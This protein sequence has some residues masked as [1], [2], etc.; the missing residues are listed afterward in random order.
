[1]VVSHAVSGSDGTTGSADSSIQLSDVTVL[2][3]NTRYEATIDNKG[4]HV[5]A[6]ALPPGVNQQL[7][8]FFDQA[9]EYAGIHIALL[10]PDNVIDGTSGDASVGGIEISFSGTIPPVS[11][12][13]LPDPACGSAIRSVCLNQLLYTAEGEVAKN[14]PTTCGTDVEAR[15]E[16]FIDP[17]GKNPPPQVPLCFGAGVAPGPGS[18]I[19]LTINIGTAESFSDGSVLDFGF[20]PQPDPCPNGCSY[21]PAPSTMN[22]PPTQASVLGSTTYSPTQTQQRAT[23]PLLG[24]YARLPSALLMGLGIGLLILAV[25]AAL[26]PSLRHGRAP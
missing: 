13:R 15:L 21:R 24:I 23:G 18:E 2:I 19:D 5:A 26:G 6:P 9:T 20:N 10:K 25:G 17:S 7:Q 22:E 3:N 1:S 4:V 12:P 14:I 16:P 8:Q 11:I